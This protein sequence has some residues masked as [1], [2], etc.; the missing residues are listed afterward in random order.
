MLKNYIRVALRNLRSNKVY[1]V[2]NIVGLAVGLACCIVIALYVNNQL[3]YD[4]FNRHSGRIYRAALTAFVNGHSLEG[5]SSPA[6]LGPAVKTDFS[7]VSAYTRIAK[8]GTPLLRYGD[9][10][11][12]EPNFLDVDSTFFDIFTVHFLKGDPRTALTQP[13]SVVLTESMARK[14]FGNEDPMGKILNADN[15]RNWLV[16][17]VIKDWPEDSHFKFDFLGSLCT[18]KSSQSTYWLSNNF[19]TY[20]LLRKGTDPETFQREMNAEFLQKYIGPQIKESIGESAGQFISGGGK[21]L[22]VLQP[23]TSIHLYSHREYELEPN[24]D[25]SYVY[26]F[27]AIAIAILLIACINFIN[28]ATARSER[29]AKEVGIR[30]TL[31]SNKLQLVRQFLTESVM[32]SL[33]AV[34]LAIGLV[35]VF[36]PVFDSVTQQHMSLDLFGSVEVIPVLLALAVAVGMLAGFYPAFYLSSFRPTRALKSGDRL[37]GGGSLLRGGLVVFQFVVSIVLFVGTFVI[38]KQLTYIQNKNLGFNKNQ[39]IVIKR[40]GDLGKSIKAFKDDLQVSPKVVSV[41]SSTAVPGDQKS[42]E[43]YWLQG[44]SA[45][46]L[47]DVR[48]MWCDYSFFKTY[49]IAL[50]SGRFFSREH[51]SDSDAVIVN[52][53]AEKAF[54]VADL[55]GRNLVAPGRR[56]S[57]QKIFPVIGV[58]QNFNFQSLHQPIHP[59]AIRFIPPDYPVQFVSVRVKPGDYPGTISFIERTWKKYAGNQTL[60]YSFLDQDLQRLYV[61]D[62]RTSRIA[63][64]FSALAIFVACLGLLGLAA[65]VTERRT[66]EIGVRKV[67]GATVPEILGLLTAQFIKWVLVANVLAWPVAYLVMNQ[68]LQSF[69]YKVNVGIPVYLL[70]GALALL[71]AFMTVGLH[72]IRAA[73][74]NPVESLRYE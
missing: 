19:Y 52:R 29:R 60:D 58:T 63:S 20:L 15:R 43:A 44:T 34:V 51:P 10:A 36:L 72:T 67:L 54:G 16:T 71:I 61:A 68:W 64:V 69:A 59:L 11:F 3:G 35:E 47:R 27:S 57:D 62:Q 74:A 37:K 50:V 30:K 28:L 5:A 9:R 2:I 24:G 7:Q 21:W 39:V 45:G 48:Q 17:G 31:G 25:I 32:M 42:D 8:F 73:T 26:V 55:V 4:S 22:Y 65:F 23:L 53:Q 70:S 13:N 46:Q 1:S 12:S 38:Y 6:P 18:F 41:S 33:L 40:A 56:E 49:G 14:Y 66:K